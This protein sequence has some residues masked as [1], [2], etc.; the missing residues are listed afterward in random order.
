MQLISLWQNNYYWWISYLIHSIASP[1]LVWIALKMCRRTNSFV[2]KDLSCTWTHKAKRVIATKRVSDFLKQVSNVIEFVKNLCSY[3]MIIIKFN[4][5]SLIK[6]KMQDAHL[7]R[8]WASHTN[9]WLR[10][11]G[12]FQYRM[13][14]LYCSEAIKKENTKVQFTLPSHMQQWEVLHYLHS[15]YCG[16]HEQH[17]KVGM[18][19]IS[20][21]CSK[22]S[23]LQK[24]IFPGWLPWA[25]Q[26]LSWY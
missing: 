16:L 3:F 5:A 24:T 11:N 22:P 17:R 23:Y 1:V 19:Q 14:T 25:N 10:W 15:L 26:G 12:L 21:T 2:I 7:K 18:F 13:I 20:S 9:H 6:C 4:H 8:P